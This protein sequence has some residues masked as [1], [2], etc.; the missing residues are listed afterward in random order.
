MWKAAFTG[1]SGP[2]ESG[3][4]AGGRRKKSSS[5]RAESVTSS[6]SRRPGE[7]EGGKR[8]R[9]S[10]SSAY[11]DEDGRSSVYATAPSSRAG[12]GALTESAVRALD[13]DDEDWEDERERDAR[14]ERKSKRSES[15][16]RRR[17][18]RS[19]KGQERSRSLERDGK[20][21]REEKR[22]EGASYR[23]GEKSEKVRG[24]SRGGSEKAIPA[25]GS[26]DQF[27]GQY[28]GAMVG[29]VPR[30]DEIVMSGALPTSDAAHQFPAQNPL[31]Y[32]RPQLGPT[33]ADS[34]GAAAEY[35]L[36]EGQSVHHQPGKRPITPNMLHN[37][38]A[39]LVAASAVAQPAEDTGHGSAADFYGGSTSPVDVSPV[40]PAS[41]S[42]RPSKSSRQPSGSTSKPPKLGKIA[43][44]AAATAATAG[45]IGLSSSSHH[46]SQQRTSST[47]SHQQT[48][49]ASARPTTSSTPQ[50]KPSRQNSESAA[51]SSQRGYST[52]ER[53]LQGNTPGA[54]YAPPSEINRPVEGGSNGAYYATPPRAD[55]PGQ[56]VPNGTSYGPVQSVRPVGVG[57]NGSYYGQP[58]Q[59]VRPTQG[60]PG[61]QP[62]RTNSSVPL[63]AA[64]AAAA[65]VAAYEM[66]QQHQQHSSQTNSTSYYSGGGGGG[67]QGPP[68]PPVT[69]GGGPYMNGN[70]GGM[71]H[72]YH[73]H[74]HKGPMTRLKD[75]LLNLISAPEDVQRM[76]EYTEYIG[77]CKHCFDPR[78]S[79]Y[80]APRQHH[81]R[82]AGRRESNE[83]LR[84][85]RSNER[86]YKKGSSESLW[87][88][89][90][91]RVDKESRYYASGKSGGKAELVGAGL[92][93][94]GVAA[95]AS[96]MYNDRKNFDD[97]YSIKSGHRASSAVR[98]R[99]RSSSRER[100]RR[101]SHGVVGGPPREEYVTVRTKDGRIEKRKVVHRSRSGSRDRKSG[102]MG[103]AA[104]AAL[105]ATAGSAMAGGS[106][107]R[108]ESE[109]NGAF[110]RQHSRSR[111]RSHS[112]GLGEIFGFTGPK[113]S[114]NSGRRSPNGATHDISRRTERR[115]SESECGILGSFFSPS[116][117]ER[118]QRRPSREHRKKQRGF[119]NFSNGSSSSSDDDIA[120]GEGFNSRTNLPLRRKRSTRSTRKNSNEH[121][122]AT[123]AG[124]GAT[125]AALAA[126]QKGHRISKRTS[127]PELG[128]RKEVRTRHAQPGHMH[129]SPGSSN[130][131]E[132]EDELPS[133]VDGASSM[134]SGLA[135][136]SRLS[137]QQSR[138]SVS[139]G[140]GLGAWGWRWGGKDKK[141]RRPSSPEQPVYPPRPGGSFVGPVGAGLAAGAVAGAVFDDTGRLVRPDS[142]ATSA[143][144]MPQQPMQYVDPRPLSDAGSRH[145]SMP[146][147][148]DPPVVRPGPGPLQHPQ[149]MAP[150]SPAFVQSPS[151]MDERPIPRRTASSPIRPSFGLQDAAL[152]GAGALAAG[153]IIASQG[154]KSTKEPSNVRFGLT[155]EQQR[156]D[157]RERRRE[158]DR[159]D[160]ERRRA[161]RTRA[162]KEEAERAAEEQDARQREEEVHRRRQDENRRAAEATLERE[163]QEAA[164]REAEQQVEIERQRKERERREQEEAYHR[165][166]ARLADEARRQE[167]SR[168]QWEALAAEEAAQNAA[169]ERA[170][171]ER[172]L[173]VQFEAERQAGIERKR[174]EAEEYERQAGIERERREAQERERQVQA[175]REYERQE[176][177]RHERERRDV[178]SS[179]QSSGTNW[180]PV[181]AEAVAAATVGA[182]LAG[183][184][185]GRN[186]EKDQARAREHDEYP[187]GQ[188][189]HH[190]IQDDHT[191]PSYAARQITPTEGASGSPLMDDDIFDRDFFKRKRSDSEF[192]RH[193][194]MSADK[195]VA[196]MDAY[197]KQPAQSQAEF[198][199]PKDILAQPSAG[200]THVADPHGDNQ[201]QVY[202][203]AD[204]NVRSHMQRSEYDDGYGKSRH[205]PYGVPALNVISP[206]PPQSTAGSVRGKGSMPSS[207]LVQARDAEPTIEPAL[208]KR[209]RSRSI[210]WG[211]DK[212]YSY[213]PPT[214]DSYQERGSYMNAR[215][216][217]TPTGASS[218]S[219][220]PLDE[221]VVEA[222]SPG[223]GT[224]T[225]SYH[226]QDLPT[227]PKYAGARN[228]IP[229][230]D[231]DEAE[232]VEA[233][234]P[235]FYRQPFA[236]SA[237]DI[238]FAMD[239]PGT[240]GAPPV[241]GFIEGE[242]D[243]PTPAEEKPQHIPGGF[244]DDVYGASTTPMQ[245]AMKFEASYGNSFEEREHREPEEAA[246]EPPL[247][248]KE[249][250]KRE[251]AALAK[252]V[253]AF[254]D[255]PS[256][257]S[258]P[259]PAEVELPPSAP[260]ETPQDEQADYFLSKK[261]KK[262]REKAAS[263]R[264]PTFDSEP[265]QP[266]TPAPLERE[267]SPSTPV[268]T[269]QEEP[270]EYSVS[271][272]DKKK[273]DKALK[274]GVS[275]V[276]SPPILEPEAPESVDESPFTEVTASEADTP[277]L[278][279]KEQKKREK[280]AKKSGFGDFAAETL[281]AAA[282]AAAVAAATADEPEDEWS[283]GGKKSKKGKKKAREADIRDIEPEKEFD[284]VMTPDTEANM[285][286]GWAPDS[287]DSKPATPL[288]VAD[289]FQ[290][291]IKD[292]PSQQPETD[293]W[294]E[295]ADTKKSKK[296]KK[297]DSGRFN[298][299]AASSPLR[300]E[301][302]YDDYMGEQATAGGD[303]TPVAETVPVAEAAYANGHTRTAEK[304][305]SETGAANGNMT[306]EPEEIVDERPRR[307]SEHDDDR[308]G[309][310]DSS[311]RPSPEEGRSRSV[312]SE[313]IVDRESRPKSKSEKAR[314]E[315]GYADDPDYYDDRSVAGSEP[316]DL[317]ASSKSSKRRSKREDDDTASI[318]SS[319]SRREKEESSAPK[320]EKKGGLFGLFSRKSSDTV[321]LSRQSTRSDEAPLS[322]TST[323]ESRNG[324]DEDGERKHRKKK[325]REGSTYGDDDD[326][327]SVTSESR[328]RSHKD[329][330]ERDE[331]SRE[332]R[333]SSRP[334][335]DDF[336]TRSEPGRK[337]RHRDAEEDD[338]AMSRASE[339]GHHHHR[340]RRTGE[341]AYDSKDPS[342][343]GSRVEDLP[344]LPA[345]PPESPA[346]APFNL[347]QGIG[348]PVSAEPDAHALDPKEDSAPKE[349]LQDVAEELPREQGLHNVEAEDASQARAIEPPSSELQPE[350][351]QRHSEDDYDQLPALPS[352]RPQ[353]P[354][355]LTKNPS[356]RGHEDEAGEVPAFSSS[357]P[358]SPTLLPATTAAHDPEHE[359]DEDLP[360]LPSS[361]PA[362]PTLMPETPSRPAQL[363]RPTSTTAI[364][365]RFPF[366]HHAPQQKERSASFS[367]PLPSAPASPVSAQKKSR[368]SSTEIR[369]LYL[370]ERNRK[371]PDV[372]DTLPSLPSSKTT[373]RASSIQGSDDWHSAAEEFPSPRS[374]RD[375]VID[376][377]HANAY[378]PDDDYLDSQE[379]TPKASEF[380][381]T[382]VMRSARKEPQF[383]TWE[384]FAQDERLHN[385]T[386]P[387]DDLDVPH[388]TAEE[389]PEIATQPALQAPEAQTEDL[390]VLPDSRPGSPY[391]AE[392]PDH[393]RHGRS[394]KGIAAAAMLGSGAVLAHRALTQHDEEDRRQH[395]ER[396]ATRRDI[397][398]S[399]QPQVGPLPA[400]VE[401]E[402][403]I[404]PDMP[405]EEEPAER[406]TLSR[407]GSAKKKK[408]GKKGKRAVVDDA[409]PPE[410]EDRAVEPADSAARRPSE[411]EAEESAQQN[412]TGPTTN[413]PRQT[414]EQHDSP[415]IRSPDV[416]GQT[417]P[418][419][420][421]TVPLHLA[422]E[423]AA[424]AGDSASIVHDQLSGQGEPSDTGRGTREIPDAVAITP[425]TD[426]DGSA[427]MPSRKS[428]KKTKKK[429]KT[430]AWQDVD[431][432][433][434]PDAPVEG[435]A[436]SQ[437]PADE[438]HYGIPEPREDPMVGS[439]TPT[440]KDADPV[441][442]EATASGAHSYPSMPEARVMQGD[443]LQASNED[444]ASEPAVS[445]GARELTRENSTDSSPLINRKKSKK[446]KKKA[447]QQQWE[448]T[449]SA[450]PEPLETP[451][452][453]PDAYPSP[454]DAHATAGETQAAD[455]P[456]LLVGSPASVPLPAGEDE[457]LELQPIEAASHQPDI[458]SNKPFSP[459]HAG[460]HAA[461]PYLAGA[462]APE[463]VPLPASIPNEL[464]AMPDQL[465]SNDEHP[466]EPAS[467]K[468]TLAYSQPESDHNSTLA[469][470][471]PKDIPLPED[472]ESQDAA[473][474]RE[475]RAASFERPKDDHSKADKGLAANNALEEPS[476]ASET[477]ASAGAAMPKSD[478]ISNEGLRTDN[479]ASGAALDDTHSPFTPADEAQAFSAT[480]SQGTMDPES[481]SGIPSGSQGDVSWPREEPWTE[482]VH[483]E[484]REEQSWEPTSKKSKKGKKGKRSSLA[485][486]PTSEELATAG[487]SSGYGTTQA[488]PSVDAIDRE[489]EAPNLQAEDSDAFWAPPSG[490]KGEK[491][492]K[493]NG[494]AMEGAPA[495]EEPAEEGS[496][497]TPDVTALPEAT[498][499]TGTESSGTK[500]APESLPEPDQPT[501]DPET[502]WT[503]SASKKKGKKGKKA[504]QPLFADA[505]EIAQSPNEDLATI[506]EPQRDGDLP[507]ENAGEYISGV[508]SATDTQVPTNLSDTEQV[509]R[510]IEPSAADEVDPLE[511]DVVHPGPVLERQDTDQDWDSISS[512]KKGK[513][514]KKS[515]QVSF[516][517]ATEAAAMSPREDGPEEEQ[518][519]QPML[520]P[521]MPPVNA[522]L[523]MPVQ[524]DNAVDNEL[525]VLHDGHEANA[526]AGTA[527]EEVEQSRSQ[528]ASTVDPVA[529]GPRTLPW[530]DE[531]APVRILN[532]E[533]GAEVDP[534]TPAAEEMVEVPGRAMS[535]LQHQ[536][537][538]EVLGADSSAARVK[539]VIESQTPSAPDMLEDNAQDA[540]PAS[541]G[542][543][544]SA[545]SLE[546]ADADEVWDTQPVKKKGKKGKK[547]RFA[548]FDEPADTTEALAEADG[549]S[550][551]EPREITQP[552]EEQG[553]EEGW[554]E[555]G[556][557]SKKKKGKKGKRP[558]TD[559]DAVVEE[560]SSPAQAREEPTPV[561]DED[562]PAVRGKPKKE[563]KGKKKSQAQFDPQ[564]GLMLEP[565]PEMPNEAAA[566]APLEQEAENDFDV[567]RDH[568][569]VSSMPLE[570]ALGDVEP[571]TLAVAPSVR[572]EAPFEAEDQSSETMSSSAVPTELH[573]RKDGDDQSLERST[574]AQRDMSPEDER[575]ASPASGK[576]KKGK[577]GKK[578]PFEA[579]W[580][581]EDTVNDE[582]QP[583]EL[584]PE[585]T[586]EATGGIEPATERE[587]DLAPQSDTPAQSSFTAPE[588]SERY[589]DL[590]DIETGV[591]P[592]A[593]EG[594]LADDEWT[595]PAA[596][597][598]KS[599][600]KKGKRAGRE[601]EQPSSDQASG[602]SESDELK[603][604][605]G[606][607]PQQDRDREVGPGEQPD[608][609]T[610]DPSVPRVSSHFEEAFGEANTETRAGED[611]AVDGP[612][613]FAFTTKKKKGKK[614]KR[615]GFE[616]DTSTET[617]RSR[618]LVTDEAEIEASSNMPAVEEANLEEAWIAPSANKKGKK[619]KRAK[620]AP[621]EAGIET[622]STDDGYAGDCLGN[623]APAT[624]SARDDV[625][626]RT[627]AEETAERHKYRSHAAMESVSELASGET[628]PPLSGSPPL[629]AEN[630]PPMPASPP[631]QA[632]TVSTGDGLPA[633]HALESLADRFEMPRAQADDVAQ[634]PHAE[635][636][637]I[638]PDLELSSAE[639]EYEPV[640]SH[641]A[642]QYPLPETPAEAPEYY[643]GGLDA[644]HIVPQ[645]RNYTEDERVYTAP[646][647][648]VT[649]DAQVPTT[650]DE[651]EAP[652]A[653]D[654]APFSAKKSK[655]DKKKGKK[656]REAESD[657]W[658]EDP[659]GEQ[660]SP[661]RSRSDGREIA[662][663]AVGAAIG[664]VALAGAD[665]A[666]AD[667]DEED[668]WP[669]IPAKH[670]KRDKRKAKNSEYS[671]PP[672]DAAGLQV[673]EDE[674]VG[675]DAERDFDSPQ[676]GYS[677]IVG[678][679]ETGP[680]ESSAADENEWPGFSSKRSKKAKKK[681]K[682]SAVQSPPDEKALPS[683]QEHAMGSEL[684][685]SSNNTGPDIM[686]PH[687]M[688]D[689][690][691]GADD[692]TAMLTEGTPQS[693]PFTEGEASGRVSD[694]TVPDA[695]QA[696]ATEE[697][698]ASSSLKPSKKDKRK[699]KRGN[700][701]STS[702]M[703][704][705]GDLV[706]AAG[707][708][709][710]VQAEPE[711]NGGLADVSRQII[712]TE[713][714][715][716]SNLTE[717]P[718]VADTEPVT[719]A[720]ELTPV[721]EGEW[722]TFT[723]KRS[724]K[725]K[726]R[727][728]SGL[729]TPAA[730]EEAAGSAYGMD[731][732]DTSDHPTRSMPQADAVDTGSGGYHYIAK[733]ASDDA[734]KLPLPEDPDEDLSANAVAPDSPTFVEEIERPLPN[735]LDEAANHP[736]PEDPEENL[737]PTAVS[738]DAP[739]F[740]EEMQHP[741]SSEEPSTTA[742]SGHASPRTEVTQDVAAGALD[743]ALNVPLPESADEN[744]P[745]LAMSRDLPSVEQYP[746]HQTAES[747]T[748]SGQNV[749]R[750]QAAAS[751]STRDIDFAATLA[752]GL[753]DS[754]FDPNM[755][756]EDPNFHRRTSPPGTVAEADPEE[757]F[758]TTTTKRGK[759]GKKGKR[760]QASLEPQPAAED[761][762][763]NLREFP[764]DQPMDDFDATLAQGLQGAGFDP[765]M[766]QRATSPS[767]GTPLN[768]VVEDEPGFSL[769]SKR[770]K[771]GKKNKNPVFA[772]ELGDQPATGGPSTSREPEP[773]RQETVEQAVEQQSPPEPSASSPMPVQRMEAVFSPEAAA[774]P[775][776]QPSRQEEPDSFTQYPEGE[777]LLRSAEGEPAGQAPL[778]ADAAAGILLAGDRDMDVDEMDKAYSA[779]KR[780]E[781][782]KKKK[783]KAAVLEAESVQRAE[784]SD[785]G[786]G[787]IEKA[788]PHNATESS[789]DE[790]VSENGPM[791]EP[792]VGAPSVQ[793]V[794]RDAFETRPLTPAHDVDD[795]HGAP[796]SPV[797]PTNRVQ[798]VFPGLQRVKR[799]QPSVTSPTFAADRD[800]RAQASSAR[801]GLL[802][803]SEV[804]QTL[805]VAVERNSPLSQPP[806]RA[807]EAHPQAV[808][809]SAGD[810]YQESHGEWGRQQSPDHGHFPNTAGVAGAALAA[811]VYGMASHMT[812][813]GAASSP[814]DSEAR[815]DH[816]T[817]PAPLDWSF[818]AIN[819][820][821]M[822]EAESPVVGSHEHQI[823]RDSGYQTANSPM[824]QRH[825]V[826]SSAR[827]V[828]DI[829]TS[830]SR[831][832]LRSRRS[833]EPLHIDTDTGSDWNLNVPKKREVDSDTHAM[834]THSRTPSREFA[835]TPLE[836]TTKNRASYLFQSP[837]AHLKDIPSASEQATPIARPSDT[838]YFRSAASD[839]SHASED[840]D[841]SVGNNRDRS[842]FSP[843]PA[844]PL[845]PRVP[846]DSIPE[847]HHSKRSKADSDVGG[848]DVI[849][850]LRRTETPQ[851][852]RTS[853]EKALSPPTQP[854]VTVPTQAF[855]SSAS[856]PL[857]TDHLINRLSWPAVDEDNETVNINRSLKRKPS[858][859]I[860]SDQRS[861]SVLS[862]RSNM[863][864]GQQLRSPEE[865]RSYSRTSN[866]SSTPTLRR[867]DRSLSGDLRSASRR[868]QA[869]SAAGSA[870]GAR[871]SP[872]TI[873][874]EPPPTPPLNDEDVIDDSAARAAAMSDDVF[875][876]YHTLLCNRIADTP[877]QG[878]GDAQGSQVSPT[879]PPSVRKRQ[880]MHITDLESK[881]DYLVAENRALQDAK[882]D[883]ERTHKA[884]SYQ[885]D[886]NNQA[887]HEALDARD[888][889]LQEKD[890]EISQIRAILQS[891]Q[892]EVAR[893]NEFNGGLTA[894]NRNLVDDTNGRYTTLQQEHAHA[895]E[896]WQNASRELDGM[897]QEHGKLTTGMRGVIESEVA[898]ALADKN[899][900]ILRL[901]EELDI[902]TEQ[903]RALQVQ[904]RSS[905][906]NDFLTTRDE[907][908][909]DGA[910]Q[911]LCQHVQ[912]WVLRFSK[913]S[914]NR[915]CRL[916]TD[917]SDEKIE[918]RLDNAILDGSDVDKLLG[919]R[920]RRR[921]VFMSVVMTMVWEYVFT[922]YLFGM[923]RE[924]RQ[925]LKTLEK[926]LA[927]VG[928]PRA[929][930]Q[931][932]ATTLTL[933]SKRPD[934]ARQ[935]ALDTEAVA[936]EIFAMLC[937]LL[938]PPSNAEQQLLTSLQKV[939]GVAVDV[940]IEMRTQRAEYIM[941]PP[942]QPEYDRNGDLVRKV[943]FNAS[944][945]NERSG[946][947][948]SNEELE[949]ERAVVKIVLF[950]LVVKKGDEVGEGEE[951]IVVCPAQ[952]LVHNEGGRGKKVVRVMSGAMEID[953][954]R[955]SR[956]SLAS[957]TPGSTAF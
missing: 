568:A 687:G 121:L 315:V 400:P 646:A 662:D 67:N 279:K 164:K 320:K 520:E 493:G 901:R 948:S 396:Q 881:L 353:S 475:E 500:A 528:E 725:D 55:P 47:S 805:P 510:G 920:I 835:E 218:T 379:T 236:E 258:T 80:M 137:H 473:E 610:E 908:Y 107:T 586:Q 911:K 427:P 198:F 824:L 879:R 562:P 148:F 499:S 931:W 801:Q 390:P 767:D 538:K 111:S 424:E 176:G 862:N 24:K 44:T 419:Q 27:P 888:L 16:E 740:V 361:R 802:H 863:S 338:D 152:I 310:A 246:W 554:S 87:R 916:S 184:E 844:G 83:D 495:A 827:D 856:N 730:V 346:L 15:R 950:P 373:S 667:V 623:L 325:H 99:S 867:I 921:E 533:D 471:A 857:S 580:P 814:A 174:R 932:R 71:D 329:R 677:A 876:S 685:R 883:F 691:A 728:K 410:N 649:D 38:D 90:S 387:H 605:F 56:E 322:R 755:V 803:N 463:D 267:L 225:T 889:Q 65:G 504:K 922:R 280:E 391:L 181:A 397:E 830:Q 517:Y 234:T 840:T 737:S 417:A 738:P 539:E 395:E 113:S 139:S 43:S 128:A 293:P 383:Y 669:N 415:P 706:P 72:Q 735:A 259:D 303:A 579:G 642:D 750:E 123:V 216:K 448:D 30:Q 688:Q 846:L 182:V 943:H 752:A 507:T 663:V 217:P 734:A 643:E 190:P 782:R 678:L 684:D 859:R 912:Q 808:Y 35:Y 776:M 942:L 197:Y 291:Q 481:T 898:T 854:T 173:R 334:G 860:I 525:P 951:E 497:I 254:N 526:A 716:E 301:W 714:T 686:M 747:A 769:T 79:P 904:I 692:N 928:P 283:F 73:Y 223:S 779:Y 457:G 84:R 445:G 31:T 818:A 162:L 833:A 823:A 472:N 724:K 19:E 852:I 333:R 712:G 127:R 940:S 560:L 522:D 132:W 239:S 385:L 221:V 420:T 592:P 434:Q 366:G 865:L 631:L 606:S 543:E 269:P 918:A 284:P 937:A 3:S 144:S 584:Q 909:F 143:A 323:R 120:F 641:I 569:T 100:R 98:R 839:A 588:L 119:F 161:D 668:G 461:D 503:S 149:P 422:E 125:A 817:R 212:T 308:R 953:D 412:V 358:V 324:D 689:L 851:A 622:P 52:P 277:N 768:A 326:T 456:E 317:Y 784:S 249:K 229:T 633:N 796:F 572:E 861:P 371:L 488:Q 316:A 849:K 946:L 62:S 29:P 138:E 177:E 880:S 416:Y 741:L 20:E 837:P 256:Q 209:D 327:R 546:R 58:Q 428:S 757:A 233:E 873:P 866:R 511:E 841:P 855:R 341:D 877:Q 377:D 634:P 238:G 696:P 732:S 318:V 632:L 754:G 257:P 897:R 352:S 587:Q 771:K 476:M 142:G 521:D 811:V 292:E 625:F 37:P 70:G 467:T 715:A 307:D 926:V 97:T 91:T 671:T 14:S 54:Y 2:S 508:P 109:Q 666:P 243:E 192:A 519:V 26:F 287:G 5:G 929:V 885:H 124:I 680:A 407:H 683:A 195:V 582:S 332:R 362:S 458:V 302:N 63:Y 947:F 311:R 742:A 364:P 597:G 46:Q 766:L 355:S 433:N 745:P 114:R 550:I 213:D 263:K 64:G 792:D 722:P 446:D 241:R 640:S 781:K 828:P 227:G 273:R 545:P 10:R 112:P 710:T 565:E 934:F 486:T 952:V 780:K 261:D 398:R 82:G 676:P 11:G 555:S 133:D 925:K 77:V 574:N 33:R 153:S 905:K 89:G 514:A 270:L 829:R 788:R 179:R 944:L 237:S 878:Y 542:F 88:S 344:P 211:E 285:P 188:A 490:K 675:P 189:L 559:D 453:G 368:P 166:Q 147:S 228:G 462:D 534:A 51:V 22:R 800:V 231:I 573:E 205:A 807:G 806:T 163:R 746:G 751:S 924:Q 130:E 244:D 527:Q 770:K 25:M 690:D 405:Q 262:K 169:K 567:A 564:L 653:G 483:P 604:D 485:T 789:A 146:G 359:E 470:A 374:A 593:V 619:G 276:P 150:I 444:V 60:T 300:S 656:A 288:E 645:S 240:E 272:K 7:E 250:K 437:V 652:D 351:Q 933:L 103:A 286:G 57:V 439:E 207:P 215:D 775:M 447:K 739:T 954:P 794:E 42:S 697:S 36:D 349:V 552:V 764:E 914:D 765:A 468:D 478:L 624:S 194:D 890:T 431:D 245:E 418:L 753:A 348:N 826:K 708:G 199:A 191:R 492:K 129:G 810:G 544:E 907:D 682:K 956:Q 449:P 206:T 957:T 720:E 523:M 578:V 186:R 541:S 512:R 938:P 798:S 432:D 18:S 698:I 535:P 455:M 858:Q 515:K 615:S 599:R 450:I 345:S 540:V 853:R 452:D 474:P 919:D 570:S 275:D 430:V 480:E 28:A 180:G 524:S 787:L 178:A 104:G 509:A 305:S 94:A 936:H 85:R 639:P 591:D 354:E 74:E 342:F 704:D 923:D 513:K 786:T 66:N 378:M 598:K 848:P 648:S 281:A 336:D 134:D 875:V 602:R 614:G 813:R 365:L 551:G 665:T 39:H 369:P 707:L 53:P 772:D 601:P 892:E 906:S 465:P 403:A 603:L 406:P 454:G 135:F 790:R 694:N 75:G 711:N 804:A 935:C 131:D 95:G 367:S 563:K 411:V 583:P 842:S 487:E 451:A 154:R 313:P 700:K 69:P 548:G 466:T 376:T 220:A 331:D 265:S 34:Y 575:T 719:S 196:D 702:A 105:G 252:S 140:D 295:S 17:K 204:E 440:T 314:S 45:V 330:D 151:R 585:H 657:Q 78:S 713:P 627:S 743:E 902:A 48:F 882:Q 386:A 870:V 321:P 86:L 637:G 141:R 797:S 618:E 347:E 93:A 289:P 650:S 435:P 268:E 903:I 122:A 482:P 363:A 832:S 717:W 636:H 496:P 537:V 651:R 896:Q 630:L 337:H 491:G 891:L 831:E 41:S 8:H 822:S 319:R 309:V 660:G 380:P 620:Q 423:H 799:R 436:T 655:R 101:S 749:S 894:A 92:A 726:R 913:L 701:V 595:G 414:L 809:P 175:R 635:H 185:H 299:P 421:D 819:E 255:E 895:H 577:K 388:G 4:V 773:L 581:I 115:P 718:P 709:P 271:K 611:G 290:Y 825:S 102:F 49:S 566:Q 160:E 516:D 394:A 834:D 607:Q 384:D 661:V 930:A 477:S 815:D 791:V 616:P 222:T 108:R 505:D 340:R 761:I 869:G 843:P 536:I 187:E 404:T 850:A 531:V 145:V 612:D 61:K 899:A 871:A 356:L 917:L 21:R 408:K 328:H 774:S 193:T 608:A 372:D 664:A 158:R 76:E 469:M 506:V 887:M 576:K 59:P 847:E 443:N 232:D 733:E 260:A 226:E 502:F 731:P 426:F 429:Q 425:T 264:T 845:S 401:V 156:K 705:D 484:Q 644:G 381:Q 941:L 438:H 247:S 820:K 9:S 589:S 399:S 729:S 693:L 777:Q 460:R 558:L 335:E 654:P 759:K 165:E 157:D 626:V 674:A 900:E 413:V 248:K 40:K 96:A 893:L 81:Y 628:L 172:Q 695:E 736:L 783:A 647:A 253:A 219:S 136:G 168:R 409:V 927:E 389:R 532:E 183:S 357:R 600:G 723:T 12:V 721:V 167:E 1:R 549:E 159:A 553:V 278:S 744:L 529:D 884:T 370:V 118:K 621:H 727:A 489:I 501:E 297:R 703:P 836:S 763:S 208:V 670:S 756:V 874:F 673:E 117:N 6:A 360:A 638:Q 201:V 235:P 617:P 32:A 868:S 224:K 518:I 202:H 864:A 106:R 816:S 571:V 304:T 50:V 594:S 915:I 214:P 629:Q 68:R 760:D 679:E 785:A 949:R 298:E 658:A 530:G 242:T 155:E 681:A 116:Q 171:R 170:E 393:Q 392:R 375:L 838:D 659:A 479:V 561:V 203:A 945:M 910:C 126:A 672:E 251:K 556:S 402:E 306:A 547:A 110:V 350:E 200:K 498:V 230:F 441:E 296:K 23:D 596:A 464:A 758:T 699:S 795:S 793:D 266:S 382:A 872:K 821:R 494:M 282:G 886:V 13:V 339:G 762:S 609:A 274:R 294:T 442:I 955:R 748:T 459:T 812:D 613:G 939:I 312:A 557:A 210:S 343:L 778:V 590:G